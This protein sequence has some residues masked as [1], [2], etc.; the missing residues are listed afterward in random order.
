MISALLLAAGQGSRVG[1]PTPKQFLYLGGKTVL[2]RTLEAL[3]SFRC[4]GEIVVVIPRGYEVGPIDL[5]RE[6]VIT[7][8]GS[9]SESIK[10]GLAAIRG[11]ITLLHDAVRP[12]IDE[13]IVLKLAREAEIYGAAGTALRLKSTIVKEEGGF[14]SEAPRRDDF[15]EA[16]PPQ[17]Y[18]TDLL[19]RAYA[20]PHSEELDN[21]PLGLMSHLGCRVRLIEGSPWYFKITH[22]PDVYAAEGYLAEREGRVAVINMGNSPLGKASSRML[23]D[24]GYRVVLASSLNAE[25]QRWAEEIGGS[26]LVWDPVSRESMVSSLLGVRESY[27]RL[28]LLINCSKIRADF[29]EEAALMMA[30]GGVIVTVEETDCAKQAIAAEGHPRG[31]T[32]FKVTLDQSHGQ[33]SQ[34]GWS[35]GSQEDP[36]WTKELARV[37]VTCATSPL[38]S[39]GGPGFGEV[40]A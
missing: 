12:F 31:V 27:G 22:K 9:R 5:A 25:V 14:L 17:A 8:G 7:G 2:E 28:D 32:V 19:R 21:N 10:N 24:R 1:T 37:V 4:L 36:Y 18:Q 29:V 33:L 11:E 15:R 23:A 35:Q 6:K 40:N 13:E 39:F 20:Q 30:G 38:F 26:A 16:G 34:E 3:R